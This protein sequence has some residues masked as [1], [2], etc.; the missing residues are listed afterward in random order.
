[1]SMRCPQCLSVQTTVRDSRPLDARAPIRRRSLC[2]ACSH[3]FITFEHNRAFDS[4][5][6]AEINKQLL[7]HF[8]WNGM[9]AELCFRCS[10][11]LMGRLLTHR[12]G[13]G[14]RPSQASKQSTCNEHN[15]Q[16]E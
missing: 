9:C 4:Q 1:M 12:T 14:S 7:E 2:L 5:L 6:G 11:A 13:L 15:K 3:R 16:N 10:A 8:G